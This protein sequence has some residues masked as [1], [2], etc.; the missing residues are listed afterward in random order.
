MKRMFLDTSA[1]ISG[2][3]AMEDGLEEE[4]VE[5]SVGEVAGFSAGFLVQE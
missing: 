4:E 2:W 1:T 5:I 3:S